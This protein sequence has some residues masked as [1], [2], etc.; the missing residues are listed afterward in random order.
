MTT[1]L[2]LGF[3]VGLR[4][5]LFDGLGVGLSVVNGVGRVLGISPDPIVG[6]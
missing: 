5:G 6:V 2:L 3:A 4:E 1:G